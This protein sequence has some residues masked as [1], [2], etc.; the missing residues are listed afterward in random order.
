MGRNRL[1]IAGKKDGEGA[2]QVANI[3]PNPRNGAK[4]MQLALHL[5]LRERNCCLILPALA[6]LSSAARASV[7]FHASKLPWGEYARRRPRHFMGWLV[8]SDG[9]SEHHRNDT[10]TLCT[11]KME[12]Q[13]LFFPPPQSAETSQVGRYI[14]RLA[15]SALSPTVPK[16]GVYSGASHSAFN[17]DLLHTLCGYVPSVPCSATARSHWRR[18]GRRHTRN[19]PA[20]CLH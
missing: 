19:V 8:E 5:E 10:V 18:T 20:N 13:A 4:A 14:W 3:H 1:S 12:S 9:V 11:L 6:V 17:V 2:S 7:A 16:P 15:A